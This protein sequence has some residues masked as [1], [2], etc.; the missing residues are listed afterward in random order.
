MKII[1]DAMPESAVKC[2]FHG[3][4]CPGKEGYLCS[5]THKSCPLNEGGSCRVLKPFSECIKNYL[6]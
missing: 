5:V 3:Y 2:K 4:R 6:R 1:V